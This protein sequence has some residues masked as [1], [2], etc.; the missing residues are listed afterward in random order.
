MLLQALSD[1]QNSP[2]TAA[3]ATTT[4]APPMDI[5]TSATDV[6]VKEEPSLAEGQEG[7][8]LPAVGKEHVGHKRARQSE[9]E[10]V[11]GRGMPQ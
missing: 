7:Q 1:E 6:Q 3:A 4:T 11:V 2:A 9:P 8:E 5:H 10:H